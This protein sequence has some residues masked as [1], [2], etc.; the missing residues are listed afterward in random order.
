M[1]TL[2]RSTARCALTNESFGAGGGEGEGGAPHG[3]AIEVMDGIL[4]DDTL[5]SLTGSYR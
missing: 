3:L 1:Y 4:C 2:E 5:L